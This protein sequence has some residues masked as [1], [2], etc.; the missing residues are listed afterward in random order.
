MALPLCSQRR[1]HAVDVHIALPGDSGHGIQRLAQARVPP[2]PHHHQAAVATVRGA[3]GD[4]ARRAHHL[5]VALSQGLGRF[6]KEPGRHFPS[7]SRPRQPKRHV[8]RTLTRARLLSHGAAQRADRLATR[9]KLLG[10]HAETGAEELAR[11]LSR[12]GRARG[13]GQSLH[14]QARQPCL[15]WDSAEAMR[16]EHPRHVLR[17]PE[18]GVSWGRDEI[19]QGPQPG[20]I[21]CRAQLE[22]LGIKPVPLVPP[23]MRPAATGFAQ[24]FFRATELSS[25][26][27]WR[28]CQVEPTQTGRIRPHGIGQDTGIAPVILGPRPTGTRSAPIAL[29]GMQRQEGEAAVAQPFDHGAPRPFDGDG[30]PRRLA[31]RPRPEPVRPPGTTGSIMVHHACP[32]PATVAVEPRDLRR[33]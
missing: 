20:R 16:L 28:F 13:H 21:G 27:E 1:R 2:T 25:P 8:R 29:V 9:L 22:P 10:Q 12:C 18:R 23:P 26:E 32:P 17:A 31:R 15:A 6:R 30:A 19:D 11:G 24:R 33:L 5:R 3:R 14:L 4:P 7:D